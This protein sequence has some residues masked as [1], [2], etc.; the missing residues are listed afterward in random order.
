MF[1]LRHLCSIFPFCFLNIKRFWTKTR[2]F[3][4][5]R[6]ACNIRFVSYLSFFFTEYLSIFTISFKRRQYFLTYA[7]VSSFFG[8][9]YSCILTVSNYPSTHPY[10]Y[11]HTCTL[12]VSLTH[13]LALV[14]MCR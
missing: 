11:I 6:P 1:F 14:F 12:I 7:V 5:P 3:Q 8:S 10:S 9:N 4:D 13:T 2:N